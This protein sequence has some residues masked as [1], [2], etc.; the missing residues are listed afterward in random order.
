MIF[1]FLL[2]FPFVLH[3]QVATD[4]YLNGA[5]INSIAEDNNS[6]W[7]A[8]YGNGIY[9]LSKKDSVWTNYSTSNNRIS[10]DFFYA[11]ESGNSLVWAGSSQGLFIFDKRSN[12]WRKRKFAQGGELGNWIRALKYDRS[13]NVLWIGRFKNLTRNDVA[14][15][16]FE[17][18]S[19][20]QQADSKTNNFISIQL[21]GDSLIWFG[22]ESGVHKF[23]KHKDYLD[24]NAWRFFTNNS[25]NFIHSGNSVSVRSILLERQNIWFGT[26][27]FI[28]DD[29]PDF[30]L[31]GIYI[32]NRA[33]KWEKISTADGLSGNGIYCM[34]RIGNNIWA[35]VYS[36][37]KST[38]KEY[39]KGIVSINRFNK[40]V[41]IIDLNQTVIK[42]STILALHFDGYNLWV[43]TDN[44][45]YRIHFA[46]PLSRLPVIRKNKK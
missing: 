23:Y 30:N 21:D 46:N 2:L 40:K 12:R 3:A 36:F 10:N 22:T 25:G 11:I 41:E 31:G 27:E 42:S 29:N 45:L 24:P 43:G 1:L 14:K 33:L 35:G 6:F 7:F 39:G 28:T 5:V 15:N 19:L 44:G 38:K 8:T 16:R 37:D 26:D 9:R 17:D 4:Q 34:E 13:Q 20:I 32:F 18:I